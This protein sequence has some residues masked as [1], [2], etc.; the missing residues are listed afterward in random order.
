MEENL[1]QE[2]ANMRTDEFNRCLENF[3]RMGEIIANAGA[4]L[5]QQVLKTEQEL[6]SLLDQS[7]DKPKE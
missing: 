6:E 4:R 7:S 1:T 5:R 3:H 2:E